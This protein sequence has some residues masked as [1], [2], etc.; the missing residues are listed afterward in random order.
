M[1]AKKRRAAKQDRQP[2]QDEFAGLKR[3]LQQLPLGDSEVGVAASGEVKMSEVLTE[4][5]APYA[6]SARTG[7]ACRVLVTLG[8]WRGMRR[9]F[10]ATSRKQ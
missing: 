8:W 4:F 6:S 7:D 2:K 3:K 5:V 10:P 9:F 1:S